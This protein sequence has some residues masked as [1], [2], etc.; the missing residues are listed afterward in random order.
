M[1]NELKD[2][3]FELLFNA[4]EQAEY[5]AKFSIEGEVKENEFVGIDKT[6]TLKNLYQKHTTKIKNSEYLLNSVIRTY[7][8]NVLDMLPDNEKTIETYIDFLA[9]CITP[10]YIEDELFE[11]L[12]E[13]IR[14]LEDD[15]LNTYL[16]SLSIEKQKEMLNSDEYKKIITQEKYKFCENILIEDFLNTFTDYAIVEALNKIT[17]N[18]NIQTEPQQFKIPSLVLK[19]LECK[20]IITKEPLKW[21]GSKSLFAYFVVCMCEKYEQKHGQK[22][23]IRPFENTFNITGVT[24]TIND[25]RKTG[26]PPVGYEII[27]EI[28]E[29]P[30]NFF[31]DIFLND[32]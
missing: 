16:D 25:I 22:R 8:F 5:N 26:T 6:T 12:N 17:N 21:E 24:G 20:G 9:T 18:G 23:E 14:E 4:Y 7:K 31:N 19:S 32:K 2:I 1:E 11:K 28:L 15:F 10:Y 27:N 29:M 30:K 13:G 3:I